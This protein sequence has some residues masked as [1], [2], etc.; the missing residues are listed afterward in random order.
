[1]KLLT[2][3]QASTLW[4][5]VAAHETHMPLGVGLTGVEG[6]KGREQELAQTGPCTEHR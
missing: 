6:S 1:M 3:T 5:L 4:L 2:V